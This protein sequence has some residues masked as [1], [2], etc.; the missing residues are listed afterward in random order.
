MVLSIHGPQKCETFLLHSTPPAHWVQTESGCKQCW[1]SP[2]WFLDRCCQLRPQ[3]K[4]TLTD[5]RSSPSSYHREYNLLTTRNL[6]VWCCSWGQPRSQAQE[7]SGCHRSSA[8]FPLRCAQPW[9]R[10]AGLLSWIRCIK[11]KLLLLS[12]FL[13]PR[14]LWRRTS[15]LFRWS[16]LHSNWHRAV[17]VS[18]ECTRWGSWRGLHLRLKCSLF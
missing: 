6:E 10:P 3:S 8:Q 11:S 2:D 5:P 1:A 13:P 18:R 12:F 16:C 9:R 7:S 4:R 14:K 15:T 17:W